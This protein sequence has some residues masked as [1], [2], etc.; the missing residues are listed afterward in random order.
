MTTGW[1]SC[2]HTR[3]KAGTEPTP[4]SDPEGYLASR[5]FSSALTCSRTG[6]KVSYADIGDPEGIPLLWLMPSGCSRWFA[7]GQ[8]GFNFF[9]ILH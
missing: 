7:V 1:L 3:M 9:L 5:R 6:M 2:Y 8:G 4:Q